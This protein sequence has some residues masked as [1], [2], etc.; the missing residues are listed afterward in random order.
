MGDVN[1]SQD[2]TDGKAPKSKGKKKKGKKSK[3]VTQYWEYLYIITFKIQI[4]I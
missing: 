1:A 4:K 2:I 3:K